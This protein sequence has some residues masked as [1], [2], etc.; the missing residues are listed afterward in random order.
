MLVILIFGGV[1]SVKVMLS[2][3]VS[4]AK[5]NRITSIL[6]CPNDSHNFDE[7]SNHCDRELTLEGGTVPVEEPRQSDIEP[8]TAPLEL[9]PPTETSSGIDVDIYLPS[10]GNSHHVHVELFD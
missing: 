5:S 2:C 4:K 6:P 1:V 8:Y 9:P 3:K 10:N 7:S